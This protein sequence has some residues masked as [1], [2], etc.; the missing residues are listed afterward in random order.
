ME[1]SFYFSVYVLL[2]SHVIGLRTIEVGFCQVSRIIPGNPNP[3]LFQVEYMTFFSI[4]EW[5]GFS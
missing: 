3:K 2:I 4:E 5:V 1:S